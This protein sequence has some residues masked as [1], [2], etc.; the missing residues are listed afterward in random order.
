MSTFR[1][2]LDEV[3]RGVYDIGITQAGNELYA[4]LDRLDKR[5]GEFAMIDEKIDPLGV[6]YL[7]DGDA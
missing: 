3:M 5:L 1:E 7:L 4:R 6:R 2:L